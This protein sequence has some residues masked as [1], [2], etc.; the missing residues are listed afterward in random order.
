MSN[1]GVLKSFYTIYIHIRHTEKNKLLLLSISLVSI[2][3]QS[4]L[5]QTP[6]FLFCF[7]SD[8]TLWIN[9]YYN[10]APPF[11]KVVTIIT[12]WHHLSQRWSPLLQFGT[13]FLKGGHTPP[14]S[15]PPPSTH[16][17]HPPS[18]RTRSSSL[19]RSKLRSCPES[20][21]RRSFQRCPSSTSLPRS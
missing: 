13:T 16:P 8:A 10:L 17:L 12:I 21:D 2:C 20:L 6:R 3:S 4:T 11:S 19:H 5:F 18:H 15:T 1:S 7:L 14:P 9:H